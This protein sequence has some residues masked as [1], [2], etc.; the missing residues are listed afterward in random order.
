MK[1]KTIAMEWI[2]KNIEIG[3]N[4]TKE[5]RDTFLKNNEQ[6]VKDYLMIK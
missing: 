3:I 4:H 6:L 2:Y 1:Y 5:Q